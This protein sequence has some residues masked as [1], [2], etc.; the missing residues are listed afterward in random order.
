MVKQGSSTRYDLDLPHRDT[1]SSRRTSRDFYE[2]EVTQ[3][4]K[5]ES[6]STAKKTG[7][8]KQVF[9]VLAPRFVL[10]PGCVYSTF[11]ALGSSAP[12]ETL[13]HVVLN[14]TTLPWERGFDTGPG[15]QT[16]AEDKVRNRIPWLACL[17]FEADEQQLKGS[18]D[19][20]SIFSATSKFAAGIEQTPTL[21]VK[22]DLPEFLRLDQT[23]VVTP[24]KTVNGE[25]QPKG[26][27][28]FIKPD[29]FGRLFASLGEDGLPV[30]DQNFCSVSRY[31]YLAHVRH[32]NTEG[33]AHAREDDEAT[34]RLFS[35]IPS[36]RTGPPGR[37]R[38]AMFVSHL[39][40]IEGIEQ[41]AYPTDPSKLIA[42]PSLHS[43]SHACLPAGSFKLAGAFESLGKT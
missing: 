37:P 29:L 2:I 43:W 10:P 25:S 11:P 16:V 23:Q 1:N 32:V 7:P 3:E 35:I 6:T 9:E 17:T 33:I 18:A 22:L 28:I 13:A 26:E 19:K 4:I 36:H 27:L 38:P 12:V 5:V 21:S 30:S 15:R 39:V 34:D 8:T 40:S 14:N 42:L 31:Q 24:Y 41:M 20:N